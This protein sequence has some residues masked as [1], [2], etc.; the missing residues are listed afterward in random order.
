MYSFFS[1]CLL[2]DEFTATPPITYI[3][4]RMNQPKELTMMLLYQNTD[5]SR[6]PVNIAITVVVFDPAISAACNKVKLYEHCFQIS[7]IMLRWGRQTGCKL[8]LTWM[9]HVIKAW[10]VIPL[11]RD[12]TI[13]NQEYS[14]SKKICRIIMNSNFNT[15]RVVIKFEIDSY[16]HKQVPMNIIQ[17]EKLCYNKNLAFC[18]LSYRVWSHDVT[19]NHKM[20]NFGNQSIL[21]S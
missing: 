14:V 8:T 2:F 18:Y 11:R 7:W 3:L 5:E 4:K 16:H 12:P 9:L 20:T 1:T 17:A 6:L 13:T 21:P 19:V 10:R 15:Q